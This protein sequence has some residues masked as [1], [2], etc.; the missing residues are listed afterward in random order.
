MN[1]TGPKYLHSR[2]HEPIN[3][4]T[5]SN[6]PYY[7]LILSDGAQVAFIAS[8]AA[9]SSCTATKAGVNNVCVEITVDINGE[10]SPNQW[11]RD[12]FRFLVTEDGL[13]PAGNDNNSADCSS[14]NNGQSC[15]A[16]V[17]KENAINY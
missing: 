4:N 16:R 3:F 10:K 15:A 8:G 9:Y 5:N 14:N 2:S 11:G 6:F 12:W 13:K 17:L 7:R 1:E